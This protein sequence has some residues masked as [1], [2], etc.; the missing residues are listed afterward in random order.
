MSF[1]SINFAS[2]RGNERTP[3]NGQKGRLGSIDNRTHAV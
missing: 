1:Y 3:A 2:D